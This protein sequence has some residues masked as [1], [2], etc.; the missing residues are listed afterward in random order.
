MSTEAPSTDAPL[1]IRQADPAQAPTTP[2][3]RTALRRA[4]GWIAGLLL[5][6]LVAVAIV[7]MIRG[8]ARAGAPFAA[9]DPG[10]SGA[11]AVAEVLRQQGV[12]VV[13]ADSLAEVEA[14]VDSAGAADATVLLWDDDRILG[15][16]Q[17]MRLLGHTE[18]L[19]LLEPGFFELE[20]L[21]P[22][23]AGAGRLD[24][25][26]DADCDVAAVRQAGTVDA[27]G[28]AYRITEDAVAT[29][30]LADDDRFGLVVTEHRGTTVTLLGLSSA[31]TNAEVATAG[32]AALVLN[33]LGE[34]ETL[35]WYLPG[36]DDLTG[37][38]VP[39]EQLT[40]PWVTP[41]AVLLI[42]VA[43]G[44]I[45]WRGRR[46]GPLV[47]EDLP[48]VVRAGE[49]MEGRA[50]L[51]QRADA[52]LHALDALRIGTVS[53]LARACGLSRLATVDEVVDAVAALTGR[54]RAA[55]AG[56]LVD[57]VPATDADLVELSRALAALEADAA[58]RGRP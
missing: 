15:T 27:S 14:A 19:V 38:P 7:A 28:S 53:R 47:V 9:D 58:A 32:N 34:R 42:V 11:M 10:P 36:R 8:S 22:G 25:A 37:G 51:Y 56:L 5:A 33:L 48:V 24:A 52:R 20:D 16:D 29:G 23:I 55:V 30:C 1:T 18:R 26:L 39:I 6:V 50:R 21:A 44:A 4:S 46:V 3:V 35:V 49:T 13:E 54:D 57:R 31:L 43:F 17:R 40:P 45:L 41:L 12:D 2:T